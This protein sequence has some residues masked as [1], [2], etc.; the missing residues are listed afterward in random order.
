MQ[1]L[2]LGQDLFAPTGRADDRRIVVLLQ[3]AGCNTQ[4][5]RVVVHER[6]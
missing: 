5:G 3:K 2:H 6:K 1:A 4:E